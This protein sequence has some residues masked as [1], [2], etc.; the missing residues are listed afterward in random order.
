MNGKGES[1]RFTKQIRLRL[2][3][4]K[5]DSKSFSLAKS[6]TK[7]IFMKY[8]DENLS[9]WIDVENAVYDN[10]EQAFYIESEDIASYYAIFESGTTTTAIGQLEQPVP[11]VF[12]LDQNFPNP[13][14]PT[15]TIRF[16]IDSNS[17]VQLTVMNVLG[18]KVRTLI[19][20]YQASGTHLAIWDGRD[21][22]GNK[23]SSGTYLYKIKVSDQV[24]IRRMVLMK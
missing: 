4:T 2:N 14:N 17:L 22:A 10:T 24:E 1:A 19:N 16:T 3:Y 21:D 11:T 7:K 13:F 15:T 6:A 8:W 23:M 20:D 18:Q 5:K 12:G 9:F